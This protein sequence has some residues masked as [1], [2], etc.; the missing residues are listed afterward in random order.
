M[1]QPTRGLGEVIETLAAGGLG[2]RA[3]VVSVAKG[4]VPP[5]GTPPTSVLSARFGAAAGVDSSS[6]EAGGYRTVVRLPLARSR[7]LEGTYLAWV[8][9]R[10]AG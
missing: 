1:T 3:A 7:P 8:D 2:R 6:V 9:L 4:L 5:E 10:A